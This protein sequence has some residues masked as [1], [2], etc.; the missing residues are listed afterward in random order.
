MCFFGVNSQ[1]ACQHYI[2]RTLK[3]FEPHILRQAIPIYNLAFVCAFFSTGSILVA[4]SDTWLADVSAQTDCRQHTF[5]TSPLIFNFPDINSL[6]A[7]VFPLTSLPKSSS[8]SD[9]VTILHRQPAAPS[10]YPLAPG[11]PSPQAS[12]E[13]YKVNIQANQPSAFSG[14][15]LPTSPFDFRSIY[16][17]SVSPALFLS[18]KAKTALPFL[19]ASFRSASSEWRELLMASKAAEE[20]KESVGW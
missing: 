1:I 14:T 2:R 6:C 13:M 18:V 4:C 11:S 17:L 20:G 3:R 9:S 15:P 19:T 16:Q 12:P 10:H 7:C 8:D 5:I